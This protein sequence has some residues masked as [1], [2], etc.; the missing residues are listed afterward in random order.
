[1]TKVG[2]T[3]NLCDRV[4]PYC[5]YA[6]QVDSGSYNSE[7][8]VSECDNCGK[9]YHAHDECMWMHHAEPDCELNGEQHEFPPAGRRQLCVKCGRHKVTKN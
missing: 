8:R 7:S 2:R 3:E 6:Y 4:C 1:M 5:N 9:K